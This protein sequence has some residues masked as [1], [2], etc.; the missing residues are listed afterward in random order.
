MPFNNS[1]PKKEKDNEELDWKDYIAFV[2]A[3]LQTTLLPI[4]LAIIVLLVFVLLVWFSRNISLTI[5]FRK[6]EF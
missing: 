3:L 5:L 2:I 1:E 6:L 4:I